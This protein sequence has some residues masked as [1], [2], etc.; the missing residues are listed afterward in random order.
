M[1]EGIPIRRRPRSNRHVL[2]MKRERVLTL[3]SEGSTKLLSTRLARERMTVASC[4]KD[5]IK[6]LRPAEK[7]TLKIMAPHISQNLCLIERFNALRRD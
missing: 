4:L 1:P 5:L 7:I 3:A 2:A 6:G